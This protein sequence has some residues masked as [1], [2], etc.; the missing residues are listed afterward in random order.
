MNSGDLWTNSALPPDVVSTL[1]RAADL[2]IRQLRKVA[3]QF[4]SA[5]KEQRENNNQVSVRLVR[6]AKTVSRTAPARPRLPDRGSR[7]VAARPR[8]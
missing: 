1:P 8:R 7:P 5:C 3:S 4:P 6:P 2:Q